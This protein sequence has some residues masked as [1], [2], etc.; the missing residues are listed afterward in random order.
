ME[1]LREV[2]LRGGRLVV[3]WADGA[4]TEHEARW[5]RDHCACDAC[6]HPETRQRLVAAHALAGPALEPVEVARAA[7]DGDA[8]VEVRF[9][10]GHR[11]RLPAARLRPAP[12][13]PRARVPWLAADVDDAPSARW[14]ALL[15]DD[16][17]LAAWLEAIARRGF[18]FVDG[19]P[20]APAATRALLERVGPL[21]CTLFGDLWDFTADLAHGD[22]AYT[23]LAI[24][25]HT[26]GTYFTDPPGLQAFHC[27]AFDGAGGESLLVDGLA[28]DARLR[29]ELPEGRRLLAETPVPWRYLEPGV[30]LR[31]VAPVLDLS[32]GGTLR[33]LRVNDG[34]RAPFEPPSGWYAAW[35]RLLA[36]A[37]DAAFVFRFRLRPG[38]VLLFDNH[39]VLHGRA[40]F[41]GHRR[42]CGAYL[43][44]DVF[45]SRLRVLGAAH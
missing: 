31:A 33:S 40:A 11:A 14:D 8:G 34:D 20:V 36:L 22:T 28:L 5:M 37:E 7:G 44:R 26:D 43:D 29:E 32:P 24:G 21:R 16:A 41:E 35:S 3:A 38:R 15:H 17:A 19:V 42:L 30:H 27:L 9:A 18:A 25:P 45:E 10:D 12:I 6:L 2:R 23:T 13:A 39:R 1:S 4:E